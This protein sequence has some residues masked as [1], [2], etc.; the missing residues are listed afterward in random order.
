MRS[1]PTDSPH[2]AAR[3]LAMALV[4]DGNYSFTE[5]RA[6]DRLQ[7]SQQLGLPPEAFK[8]VIETF[9]TDLLEAAQGEWTGSARMD[10]GTR[11]QLLD[12]VR[13]PALRARMVG[14]CQAV[15]LADGHEADGE[16]ALLDAL[17]RAWRDQPAG[18]L[19]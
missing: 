8:E 18:A 13:D 10:E 6:L 14:L 16:A 9:C 3:L 11:Q 5:L 7:A 2:A 15:V 12:E 19:S 4:A 1:Y 17:T